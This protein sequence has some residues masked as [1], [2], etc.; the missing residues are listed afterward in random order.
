MLSERDLVNISL[1]LYATLGKVAIFYVETQRSLSQ[2]FWS[3]CAPFCVPGVGENSDKRKK[4][5]H[6]EARTPSRM[7]LTFLSSIHTRKH[8]RFSFFRTCTTL[9]MYRVP[10]FLQCYHRLNHEPL[11]FSSAYFMS[12]VSLW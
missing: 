8:F 3:N 7:P 4:W 9:R 12:D 1:N 6:L 11:R 5:Y 2:A 10:F